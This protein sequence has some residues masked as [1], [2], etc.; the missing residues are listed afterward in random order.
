LQ[1]QVRRSYLD[2]AQWHLLRAE[3]SCNFYWGE[4]WIYRCHEDLN[5]AWFN[6]NEAKK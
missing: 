4:V 1:D 2:E 3:T 6:M 5:I